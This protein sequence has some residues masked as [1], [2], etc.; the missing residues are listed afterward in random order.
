MVRRSAS[1]RQSFHL[2]GCSLQRQHRADQGTLPISS[3]RLLG[4]GRSLAAAD[5]RLPARRE[6]REGPRQ[7]RARRLSLAARAHRRQDQL[8]R[9][10]ALRAPERVQGARSQDRTTR[11]RPPAHPPPPQPPRPLPASPPPPPLAAPPV[12]PPHPPPPP[13]R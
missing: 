8:R 6:N 13:P 12:P 5:R 1:R 10:P 4:L 2:L 7:R 9:R 11:R 3:Q